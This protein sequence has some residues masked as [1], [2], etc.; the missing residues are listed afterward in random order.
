[1]RKTKICSTIGP[2]SSEIDIIEGLIK[3]GTDVFRLNFSHGSLH[4]HAEAIAKI[5]K[6]SERFGLPIPIMQDLQGP[7]IRI[8]KIENDSMQL[9]RGQK[10][11]VTTTRTGGKNRSLWT[12][13][14]GLPRDL[15]KDDRILLDDGLIQLRVMSIKGNE[16]ACRVIEGGILRSNKGINLP[17]VAISLPALTKKDKVDLSF[18]LKHDIDL[19]AISFVRNADDLRDIQRFMQR[20]KSHSLLIS[21]LEKPEA[22]IDLDNILLVSDGVIVARG[23]LGVEIA[24]ERVPSV[25]K[26]ILNRCRRGGVPSIVATHMLESMRHSPR[27]TRAEVSDVA[28]A[29]HEG[30]DAVMLTAETAVGERPV[31]TVKMLARIIREAERELDLGCAGSAIAGRREKTVSDAVAEAACQAA[32]ELRVKVI[33]TL[34]Q[35]GYTARMIAKYK[36]E[37]AI[38]A[39]TP[40]PA[41]CR[42]MNMYWGVKPRL[43]N[44]SGDLQKILK[45][46]DETLIKEKIA[47]LHEN[48][49]VVLG[50]P[51][52]AQGTTNQMTV[53][54]IGT[55]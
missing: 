40:H 19:V 30:A 49:I 38:L 2:A 12:S 8:G 15:H 29:V 51:F 26:R 46:L 54:T 35:S 5:R 48:I 25:Q 20:H 7:K 32:K 1:M 28:N 41:V 45:Q 3:A 31:Q 13:Y 22:V 9:K 53:H 34:T 18:G 6:A 52:L 27:P 16:I 4:D 23:D 47:L 43:M 37:A 39:F 33:V 24:V 14:R 21:K 11:V 50:L 42:Q 17:G 55:A 36:P 44:F 10:V